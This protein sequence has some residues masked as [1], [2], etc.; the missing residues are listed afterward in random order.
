MHVCYTAACDAI[1][2]VVLQLQDAAADDDGP[3]GQD[4]ADG[5]ARGTEGPRDRD[6]VC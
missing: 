2:D 6:A 4:D 1:D 3:A 5:C